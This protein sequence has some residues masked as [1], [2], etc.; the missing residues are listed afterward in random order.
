MAAAGSI[1]VKSVPG[2]KSLSQAVARTCGHVKTF[3]HNQ[4]D[5]Y[6]P[7]EA[8]I[9]WP[10]F[11]DNFMTARN[12]PTQGLIPVAAADGYIQLQM[13]PVEGYKW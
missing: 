3:I 11:Y 12:S 5:C 8:E 7:M 10:E 6:W 13:V 1:G 4:S 9:L 2:E